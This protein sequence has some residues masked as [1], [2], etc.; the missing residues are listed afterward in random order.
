MD[1]NRVFYSKTEECKRKWHVVDATGLVI[2]RLATDVV[3]LLR[4]KGNPDFTPHADTGDFVVVINA[5]KAVF[6]GNK[7]ADKEYVWYTG[8]RSGQKRATAREKS[9]RDHEF[10][11][12]HAVKGM[13][14]RNKMTDA[15]I[16][17]LK[18]YKGSEHPHMQAQAAA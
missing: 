18:I 10:L 3:A 13:M 11:V 1:M 17:R 9:E 4:G 6:T 5:D 8:F 2:G 7:M 12:R 15:Q 14:P 16:K